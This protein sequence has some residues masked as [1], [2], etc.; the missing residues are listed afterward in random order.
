[1]A[2]IFERTVEVAAW[3]ALV[4]FWVAFGVALYLLFRWFGTL[5]DVPD[6]YILRDAGVYALAAILSA[7]VL[8]GLAAID[9]YLFDADEPR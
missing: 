7:L 6:Y 1:M 9:R 3:L 2:W 5:R 8:G 4:L